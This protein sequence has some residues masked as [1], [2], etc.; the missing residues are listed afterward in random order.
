MLAPECGPPYPKMTKRRGRM[1]L[2]FEGGAIEFQSAL[3]TV[4]EARSWATSGDVTV[5]ET[6]TSGRDLRDSTGT[7]T[8]PRFYTLAD[9]AKQEWC[10]PSYA[11]L[12]QHVSRARKAGN[13][14][15][16]TTIGGTTKYTRDELVAMLETRPVADEEMAP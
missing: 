14:P 4:K 5:P 15:A 10:T 16:G 6:W 13:A 12:R 3:W 9:A 2:A 8:S 11:A 7:V 1:Y